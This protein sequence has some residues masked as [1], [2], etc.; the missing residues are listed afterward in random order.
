MGADSAMLEQKKGVVQSKSQMYP[1]SGCGGGQDSIRILDPN[2]TACSEKRDLFRQ[3]KDTRAILDFTQG[4][5]IRLL[6]DD[7]IADINEMRLRT[8]HFAWDN[9]KEKLED[10]FSYFSK[11]FRRKSKGMVYCL[12][13]FNSTMDENLHRIYTLRDL[14]FDP[15]VMIYNKPS[16]PHELIQLQYW[17][18]SKIVFRT[19][20]NFND[21]DPRTMR[22]KKLDNM[23][24]FD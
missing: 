24:L 7:D 21:F 5:D 1:I 16:A 19:V 15:Y 20:P 9:P 23:S 3:Y 22:K 12:T 17:C 10:R 6:D 8:I 11:K 2:I 14:G 18:N 4:L 13:G